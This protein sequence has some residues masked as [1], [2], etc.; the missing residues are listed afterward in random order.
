VPDNEAMSDR[1][2]PPPALERFFTYRLNTLAKLNDMATHAVYM[3]EVGL[4]LS[5]ARTLSSI[6]S[7]PQLTVN[8]LAFEA[9]LDKGQASRAAQSLVD[10]GL[11]QKVAS[12]LDGRSVF[13]A[14]T[15]SGKTLWRKVMAQVQRRN[16]ALT[17]CLSEQE[18][19]QLLDMFERML[20]Q[21]KAADRSGSP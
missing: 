12:P 19:Q 7:F 8:Q 3:A 4:G 13:L 9:N 20:A 18:Y 16:H 21:A 6:G 1:S 2:P 10:K 15:P 5:E 14:L 11:V 17:S